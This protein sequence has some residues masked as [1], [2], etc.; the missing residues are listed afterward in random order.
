[1]GEK[2][3]SL[4]ITSEANRK[5]ERKNSI[6][7]AVSKEEEIAPHASDAMLGAAKKRKNTGRSMAGSAFAPRSLWYSVTNSTA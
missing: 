5:R 2:N 4:F 3:S 6:L 1:M 7:Q